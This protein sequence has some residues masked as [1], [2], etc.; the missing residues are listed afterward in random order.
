MWF[1]DPASIQPHHSCRSMPKPE[2]ASNHSHL[3]QQGAT[4]PSSQGARHEFARGALRAWVYDRVLMGLTSGWYQQVLSRLP[5]GASVLDV[6]IGTGSAVARSANLVR[7]KDIRIVGLD[8]DRD[9]LTHCEKVIRRAGLSDNVTPRLTSVYDHQGGP[10]DAV[11][12]S[13]SFMLLPD[14]VGAI[15]HVLSLL[16][17]GGWIFFTQ[18]FHH[19][20]SALIEKVKPMLHRVTS[21]HF[22]RVTYEVDFLNVLEESGLELV[23]FLTMG[24]TRRA[25]YRLAI[26]R[27]LAIDKPRTMAAGS[28]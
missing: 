11:Y 26:A 22:G 8:I 15:R 21:I 25:S 16:A 7:E 10:Y 3:N 28:I 18:T 19:G 13:A 17:P 6:G 12:F 9:Y 2:L 23:E 1:S 24:S 5:Q 4:V 14:P 20:K 27:P